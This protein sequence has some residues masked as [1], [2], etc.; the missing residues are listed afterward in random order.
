MPPEIQGCQYFGPS[1][2][3]WFCTYPDCMNV[4]CNHFIVKLLSALSLIPQIQFPLVFRSIRC[5]IKAELSNWRHHS[6][7]T[8]KT[9]KSLLTVI[10]VS[11]LTTCWAE[12]CPFPGLKANS[13]FTK[14]AFA[15]RR[16]FSDGDVVSFECL[17]GFYPVPDEPLSIACQNGSWTAPPPRCGILLF[18]LD[19]TI[20]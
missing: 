6:I 2:D 3:E 17:R 16:I 9:M 13:K 4:A 1:S 20:G 8:R 18:L 11:C 14:G 15:A 12:R 19:E 10:C 5:N 7:L